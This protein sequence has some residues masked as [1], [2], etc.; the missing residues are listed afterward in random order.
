MDNFL[1][2]LFT[3]PETTPV[4]KKASNFFSWNQNS[5]YRLVGKINGLATDVRRTRFNLVKRAR[6]DKPTW[7]LASRKRAVGDEVRHHLL[8]YA[9]MRE[10]PY[11][12][13]ERKCRED[14]KPSAS[15]ILDI[16]RFHGSTRVWRFEQIQQWLANGN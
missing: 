7:V 2:R 3:K 5:K 1:T 16:V 11:S 8:A 14:N 9:F 4:V 10:I 6:A 13:L 15:K 12:K